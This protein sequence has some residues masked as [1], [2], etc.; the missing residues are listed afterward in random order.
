LTQTRGGRFA[1]VL[2]LAATLAAMA[3]FQFGASLAAK[4]LFPAVGPQGAAALR[5]SLGA[6]M[7][8][9]IF[10]PWRGWRKGA[11]P[12]PLVG[13]GVSMGATI[14]LFYLALSRVPQGIAIALQFLGP[15][16]V[17]IFGSR[18]PSDLVWAL[19][20]A[21]GVWLM[22]GA[23]AA[24]HA[25][26]PLGVAFALGAAIGW[27]NYIV[28]GRKAAAFGPA[29]ASVAVSVAAIVA[30]PIG[31]WR[32]GWSLFTPSLLPVALAVA[33]LAAALPFSL[34]LYALRRLPARTFAIFTSLEPALG[35]LA[36][37]AMLGQR[38]SLFQLA[39]VAGVIAAAAG[40][41]FAHASE[42]SHAGAAFEE[43]PP[44]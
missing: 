30:V 38:L 39:G 4:G 20:A 41:A 36:G 26:D 22:V 24:G 3:S 6:L 27:G 17:A 21:G 14:V 33:L 31:L 35:V 5:L 15:L 12:L 23:P 9:A 18:R 10:R 44:T 7:L 8:L 16:A 28:V 29:T 34:E 1:P 32:A 19:L 42:G 40:A 25:I 2:P 13:L 11:S 43:A 37:F